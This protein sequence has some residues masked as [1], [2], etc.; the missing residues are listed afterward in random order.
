MTGPSPVSRRRFLTG[1][2]GAAVVATACGRGSGSDDPDLDTAATVAALERLL[3]D[4]YTGTLDAAIQGRLGAAIPEVVVD[5]LHT[6]AGQHKAHLDAW[7]ELLTS[8][9]RPAVTEPTP[10][11]KPLVDRAAG[12][13][14]DIPAAA[15]LVLRLEDYASRTYVEAVPSLRRPETVRL[16]SQI[17]VVDHQRQAVLRWVLGLPPVTADFAPSDPEGSRPPTW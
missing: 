10:R 11:L 2:L 14:A 13:A 8:G 4:T 6:G 9:G 3:T 1:A 5:L 15:T 7:N 17:L 16:A 12:R